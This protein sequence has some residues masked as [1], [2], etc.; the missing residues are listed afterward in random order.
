MFPWSQCSFFSVKCTFWK[1]HF[2]S[3]QQRFIRYLLCTRHFVRHRGNKKQYRYSPWPYEVYSLLGKTY[4][5]KASVKL[6]WAHNWGLKKRW[7]SFWKL[8]WKTSSHAKGL[9]A[10]GD[11]KLLI[12]SN[13]NQSFGP[14][15]QTPG[16]PHVRS[17]P[18]GQIKRHSEGQRKEIYCVTWDTLWEEIQ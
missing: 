18:I 8:E 17:G 5:K 1:A 14:Q 3:L 4:I 16:L 13:W 7:R 12:A 6:Y 15:G 10:D 9:A 11:D 2:S